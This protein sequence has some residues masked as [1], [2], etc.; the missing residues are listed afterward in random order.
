M[1]GSTTNSGATGTYREALPN[2]QVGKYKNLPR[3]NA[4]TWDAEFYK[5]PFAK[6]LTES[7]LDLWAQPFVGLTTDGKI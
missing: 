1:E 5:N 4:H 2:L 3:H 7:W 6:A